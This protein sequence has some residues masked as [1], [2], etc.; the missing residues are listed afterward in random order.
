M[1]T[2]P[3]KSAGSPEKSDLPDRLD[4]VM[5]P[6][7]AA[8]PPGSVDTRQFAEQG[9]V[10]SGAT[11]TPLL[12]RLD[13]SLDG[14]PGVVK[15]QFEGRLE[16]MADASVQRW[17]TLAVSM[18]A[19]MTCA[20]CDEP[21]DMAVTFE[22]LFLLVAD[23]K[24]AARLDDEAEAYDVLV[25]ERR[26]SLTDLLEDECLMSLPSFVSHLDCQPMA[27]DV[28][29]EPPRNPFAV[30]AALRKTAK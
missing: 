19:Q 29:A 27:A 9:A 7:G 22:R 1:K 4:R 16:R 6:A 28:A 10:K 26:F 12:E 21:A 5:D 3:S 13:T 30:L 17:L 24:Q 8:G 23:E 2:E 25:G 20:R 14:E 11:A 15:W 18:R